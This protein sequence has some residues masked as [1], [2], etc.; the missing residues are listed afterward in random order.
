MADDKMRLIRIRSG[1][2]TKFRRR[3]VHQK[4][5]LA[6]VWRRPRGHHN[7]LRRQLKAKG[8][9]PK[10]GY[11]GP[12]LVRGYH[13]SGYQEVL[14]YNAADLA[15]LDPTVHVVRIGG[16]VGGRK[17]AEIQAA[18]LTSGLRILNIRAAKAEEEPEPEEETSG[19]EEE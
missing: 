15:D 13:P 4:K 16:S 5:K 7:K 10:P 12:S 14:V 18:A 19:G 6:D 11:G 1:K 3:G 8:P 17:R 2:E 9:I